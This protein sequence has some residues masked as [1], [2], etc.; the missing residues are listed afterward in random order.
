MLDLP[1]CQR[2]LRAYKT[3]TGVLDAE[4]RA[5]SE[6]EL[7]RETCRVAVEEAGY[8]L[9]WIGYADAEPRRVR[10]VAHYGF[11][12]GYLDTLGITW[13][14]EPRGHG[15]TGTAIRTR[16]TVVAQDVLTNPDFE[17][18]RA[19]ALRR[20]YASSIAL[21]LSHGGEVFGALNLYAAEPNAFDAEEIELLERVAGVCSRGIRCARGTLLLS[22]MAKELHRVDRLNSAG[23]VAATIAHDVNNCLAVV[24]PYLEQLGGHPGAMEASAAI[25]RAVALNRE[26]FDF[27]RRGEAAGPKT[28]VDFCV[29]SL[30]STLEQAARPATL[31]LELDADPWRAR[32]EPTDLDRVLTN[33]VVNARDAMPSGGEISVST[34]KLELRHPLSAPYVGTE[35]GSYVSLRVRDSGSGISPEVRERLFEPFFTTKGEAGSGLGLPSVFGIVRRVGGS[36]CVDSTPGHG[37]TFEVLLPRAE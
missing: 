14:D 12:D 37:A 27:A 13:D 28:S 5:S 29:R 18:W 24:V 10:P 20:G 23:R 9:A 34:R 26:L 2:L 25:E 19:E 35:A 22:D 15:P 6:A 16:K 11:D 1:T 36:V 3:L 30:A 32:V 8:R 33:L 31:R 17:P 4:K 21:V 7:V